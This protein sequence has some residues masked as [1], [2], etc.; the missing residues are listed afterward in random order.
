MELVPRFVMGPYERESCEF[1]ERERE[2]RDDPV[3]KLAQLYKPLPF[4]IPHFFLP[5][6]HQ[7]NATL[8]LLSFSLAIAI[9]TSISYHDRRR[10][11]AGGSRRRFARRRLTPPSQPPS[12]G[13]SSRSAASPRLDRPPAPLQAD[14]S[15]ACA[16]FLEELRCRQS[17]SNHAARL[18]RRRRRRHLPQRR[19]RRRF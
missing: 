6:R 13:Q 12:A 18:E 9:G 10:M 14:S 3:A 4:P 2:V 11:A 8:F 1:R 16:R 7:T 19:I 15:Q 17:Q 5:F